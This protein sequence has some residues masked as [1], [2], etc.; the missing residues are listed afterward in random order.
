M[1]DYTADWQTYERLHWQSDKLMKGYTDRLT[2]LSKTTLTDWQTYE[3]LHWQT[4]KFMKDYTDRQKNFWKTTLTDWQTYQRL[5]WQTDKLIKDYTDRL[6]NLS[7]TGSMTKWK[8]E[9]KRLTNRQTDKLT[10][11][12]TNGLMKGLYYISGGDELVFN[13]KISEILN[14][15]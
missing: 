11:C 2:N 5:H 15:L 8:K 9:K 12:W 4:H 1:K 14:I 3:R 6:T 7:K 13:T 10:N